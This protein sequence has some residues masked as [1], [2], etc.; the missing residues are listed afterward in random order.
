MPET[1]HF[2][3]VFY[4]LVN[5]L[6]GLR[7]AP[8]SFP[9]FSTTSKIFLRYSKALTGEEIFLERGHEGK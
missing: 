8:E 7:N 6:Q 9:A 4:Y 5:G 2:Y 3:A 1:Y